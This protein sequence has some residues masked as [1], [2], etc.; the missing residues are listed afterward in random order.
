MKTL[1][2]SPRALFPLK[3]SPLDRAFEYFE[4][5]PTIL[6][7]TRRAGKPNVMTLS[8]HM[9]VDFTP[10]IACELGSWDYSYQ[11]LLKSKCCVLAVPGADLL[12]KTVRIGNCSGKDV[13]KFKK[14]KLTE[15]PAEKVDAP[16]VAECLFNLECKLIDVV[17]THGIVVLQGVKAW[18]NPKCKNKNMFHAHGDGRFSIDGKLVNLRKEM[19]RWQ[20][21][22]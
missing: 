16:L 6:L 5:G 3:E 4:P 15:L 14:F 7:A 21:I 10:Q 1:K 17:K 2:K 12:L 8:W 13:D 9:P 22:I 11:S 18:I 19:T 20:S